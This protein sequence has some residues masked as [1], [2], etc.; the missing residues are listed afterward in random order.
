MF[1]RV[2]ASLLL[3]APLAARAEEAAPLR[4]TFAAGYQYRVKVHVTG[5]GE[6][7]LPPEKDK[8]PPETLRIVA[9]STLE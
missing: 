1:P 4:E 2:C 8:A 5:T 9:K 3:L 6:M 7:T